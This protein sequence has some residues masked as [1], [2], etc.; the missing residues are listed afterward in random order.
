MRKLLRLLFNRWLLVG[1]GLLALALLIWFGGP[2]LAIAEYTPLASERARGVLIGLILLFFFGRLAWRAWRSKRAN[3][4][5]IDGLAP[6]PTPDAP[7]ED[8]EVATLRARFREAVGM[9]R[10]MHRGEGKRKS[11]AGWV[12]S[13]AP[14]AHLYE[15][16]WYVFIG[17]PGAGKTTALLNS[18]T[19]F[20]AGR[21]AGSGQDPGRRRNPQLRLVV[22]RAGRAA[23]YGRPLHHA[24]QQ[25][26]DGC[27]CLAGVPRVAEEVSPAL[28]AER[29]D[30]QREREQPARPFGRPS[31][32]RRPRRSAAACRNCSRASASPCRSTCW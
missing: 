8:P 10:Q 29:R 28:S 6:A 31:A 14:G 26:R 4:Q 32:A 2:L 12:Q 24:G 16:P 18:G 15:L 7:K 21:E 17:A 1:L 19:A 9:L 25:S 13:L 30:R 27:Q 23:R 20:S 3:A 22:H 11:L 5:L